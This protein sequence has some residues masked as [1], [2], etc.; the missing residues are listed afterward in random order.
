MANF[1]VHWDKPTNHIGIHVATCPSCNNGKG[2]HEE[3]A[4][5]RGET[6][7]WLPAISYAEAQALAKA[8]TLAAKPGVNIKDCGRCHPQAHA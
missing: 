1:F 2:V 5:R 4:F 7:D 3:T 6:H 8:L